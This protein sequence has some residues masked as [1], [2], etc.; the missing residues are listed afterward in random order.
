MIILTKSPLP[1]KKFRAIFVGNGKHVDFGAR[2][3]SDYTIHRD[4]S[5]MKRY[6]E[7]HRRMGENW[8]F[9]GRYS[10]GF[11]SRW[12]LWSRPSIESAIDLVAKRLKQPIQ[13]RF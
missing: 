10:A 1:K 2:G 4:A 3:Y 13:R 11:W 9:S 5:R 7:R 8:T 6:L 12:L